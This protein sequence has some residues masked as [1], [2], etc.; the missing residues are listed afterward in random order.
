M[1]AR[2][3]QKSIKDS[4]HRLLTDQIESLGIQAY[5]EILQQEIKGPNGSQFLFTGLANNTIDS[6]KSFE[7]IDYCWV[8]EGQS[9]SERSWEILIP[10]IRNEGSEIWVTFNP[11]ESTDPTYQRFIVNTPPDA[12]VRRV[13][14]DENPWFPEVLKKEKDYLFSVDPEAAAHIW[15]GECRR[16][17][18]AQ[19]LRGRYR[20]ESF[21]PRDFWDGP[22]QGVDW[23]FAVDP[24]V[25]TRCWIFDRTLYVEYEAYGLGV[26]TDH[27][28]AL[29]DEI[30]GSRSY[31][32]RADNARPETISYMVRKGFDRMMACQK[33]PGC[34]EDR[35]A[36]LRAFDEIIIHP[37]CNHTAEE[38][39]LWSF[40]KD[41]L[42]GDVL[43]TLLDKHNH[44]WDSIAYSLEPM[45]LGFAR[46]LP[47]R[48]E[49]EEEMYGRPSGMGWM[50]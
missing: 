38:A 22:Y 21:E 7:G 26:E 24:S 40:K 25:M 34:I 45:V 14:F 43:P 27:L 10:T 46:N 41:K 42:S 29:F 37:R 50:A 47:D 32:T 9:V 31:V 30:P 8:E 3:F 2:E 19:V 15:M 12:L 49:K 1:C 11:N 17:S 18:D 36:Y 44:C 5:F 35:V 6:I 4:V 28:P 23:G 16:M 13:N 20:V 48:E 33:W 39:H